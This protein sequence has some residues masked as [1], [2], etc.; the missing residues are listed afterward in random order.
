MTRYYLS[1]LDGLRGVGILLV[2]AYH[3]GYSSARHAWLCISLFFTLSGHLITGITLESFE[4]S[5]TLDLV[6][7]WSR[8]VARLFPALLA[9]VTF[10]AV[11]SFF[12]IEDDDQFWHEKTDLYWALAYLTNVN[13]VFFRKDD[14]FEATLKPSITRHLWTL[15]IEE[16]YYIAWPLL[17][18]MWTKCSRFFFRRR[19]SGTR[20]VNI[21]N[22]QVMSTASKSEAEEKDNNRFN[23]FTAYAAGLPVE[24]F[25]AFAVGECIVIVL[26][27]FSSCLTIKEL[28]LS[29]AYYSTWSRAGDFACGGLVYILVR[30]NPS[31]YRRYTRMPGLQKMSTKY[32]IYLEIGVSF[33]LALT[34]L[35]PMVQAPLKDLLPWYFYVW[36]IP[37]S[38]SFLVASVHG[39]LQ[40]S[41]PLPNWAI[42]SRFLTCKVVSLLGIA[43]YGIYL[44][45]WPLIVL[46]GGTF[47]NESIGTMQATEHW[48]IAGAYEGILWRQK[49][50]AKLLLFVLSVGLGIGS[51][52]LYEK[53]LICLARRVKHPWKV[54]ANGIA[55]TLLTTVVVSVC[56]SGVPSP[57]TKDRN[58]A[59]ALIRKLPQINR[60]AERS[61][62]VPVARWALRL[63]DAV[64]SN[65]RKQ[66]ASPS[67]RLLPNHLSEDEEEAKDGEFT[68]VWFFV[69]PWATETDMT[70]ETLLDANTEPEV[71]PPC[72]VNYRSC[73]GNISNM[74]SLLS[75][76][77]PANTVVVVCE[78][79]MDLSPCTISKWKRGIKWIWLRSPV[80]CGNSGSQERARGVLKRCPETLRIETMEM[81]RVW[82]D[83]AIKNSPE[84]TPNHRRVR[85]ATGSPMLDTIYLIR[86]LLNINLVVPGAINRASHLRLRQLLGQQE[87]IYAQERFALVRDSL[88]R[89]KLLVLGESIAAKLGVIFYEL[90]EGSED[91]QQKR[92]QT[93]AFP[94]FNITN[95]AIRGSHFVMHF[96]EC[97]T[98]RLQPPQGF[99]DREGMLPP[100]VCGMQQSGE[101]SIAARSS[102]KDSIPATQPS[103]VVLHDQQWGSIR[104]QNLFR[105]EQLFEAM[106]GFLSL[107]MNNS[108]RIVFWLTPSIIKET[109][110]E[111]AR[112]L[113]ILGRYINATGCRRDKA[114][115]EFVVVHWHRLTC[116]TF[117]ETRPTGWCPETAHGFYKILPDYVHPSGPP[118]TWLAAQSLSAIMA[119]AAL[120]LPEMDGYSSWD[121]ALRNPVSSCLLGEQPPDGDP[122]LRDLVDGYW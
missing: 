67:S 16:Q 107:A 38:F 45:H 46:L 43:S 89:L 98:G 74:Y 19:H 29:A 44:I 77:Q 71:R 87:A 11:S 49:Q 102:A 5:G 105:E 63:R 72:L 55:G 106:S 56:Y 119:Y 34:V 116:P 39:G 64:D 69:K 93:M 37:F 3:L 108:V 113:G 96:L 122:P 20:T 115:I 66:Y 32:R 85:S 15:S 52:L 104:Y 40:I 62:P 18:L 23:E 12:R 1:H 9:V 76:T 91:C 117:N 17:F 118:G 36:R 33:A 95:L 13:M 24:F 2:M 6:G 26:S 83:R 79:L 109:G 41:E 99:S 103:I 101:E 81:P 4:R 50:L 7:F 68:P 111:A 8:R 84:L 61:K 86:T 92:R 47:M 54:L 75:E 30:L 14:Y 120:S 73:L 51:F 80:L 110:P 10:C 90:I 58:A 28:G 121:A 42:V 27:Y 25:W 53:P 59:G 22:L 57:Y 82:H 48:A 88:P 112:E 97:K 70:L 60:L 114:G 21:H 35:P 100:P 65:A 94:S 31:L 78:S